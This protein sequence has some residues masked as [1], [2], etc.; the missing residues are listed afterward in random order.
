MKKV[1]LATAIASLTA[2]QSHAGTV[3]TDGQDIVL[4]TKGGLSA[5]T[6]D[7][8]FAFKIGGRAM[9]D[10]NSYDGVMNKAGDTTGSDLFFRRA[11]IE[12]GGKAYD[13]SYY[14]SYNLTGGGSI[15]EVRTTYEGLGQMAHLTFGQQGESFGL[16]DTGSSKWFTAIEESMPSNAF[17]TGN[18]VGVKLHGANNAITY[19]LGAYKSA[20]DSNNDMDTAVTG[21]FV[22]RPLNDEN[23]LIH[24]GV[25]A[26]HRN[27]VD[28]RYHALLGVRGGESKTANSI[29]AELDNTTGTRD[30]YNVELAA[31]FGSF[32]AMAEYFDG[33][34]DPDS[35]AGKV[36]ANGYYVQAGYVLTGEQR[37]YKN[38]TGSFDSI[39]PHGDLGAWEVF[40]RYD[41]LDVSDSTGAATIAANKANSW[42]AGV[43]W[44]VNPMVKV[45]LNYVDAKTDQPIN[46]EDNGQAVVG[47]LQVA[48]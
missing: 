45:A 36:K 39:K 48:F 1:L 38:A 16:E 44:Y 15:E 17:D 21:R 9:L 7:G 18:S 20:I 40:A 31:R 35:G 13:W 3:T 34:I 30:D 5:K 43:N 14:F 33:Q 47:R 4:S 23:G 41:N 25:G 19:S 2:I 27:G 10:Y 24:L 28:A 26:T 42:T 32:H 12:M 37:G 6:T 11:R 22:Y 8:N 29:S 46:G